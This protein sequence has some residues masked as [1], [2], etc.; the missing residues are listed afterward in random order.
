M[1]LEEPVMLSDH[2]F[3][4]V[5]EDLQSQD[6]SLRVATLKG[7]QRHPSE[8]ARVLS[9]LEVMLDDFTPCVVMLPHH[10]GELRWLAAY[11]LAAERAAMDINDPVTLKDVLKPL[12]I[13]EL[14]T[15]Q[16]KFSLS[17]QKGIEG[18]LE[19]VQILREKKQLPFYDLKLLPSDIGNKRI[20]S[21]NI[22]VEGAKKS[23]PLTGAALAKKVEELEKLS[24]EEKAIACGYYTVTKDGNKHVN[25]INFFSAIIK[26]KYIQSEMGGHEETHY[27]KK[28]SKKRKVKM[29]NIY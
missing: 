10:F 18:M 9:Y 22:Q 28:K 6:L 21:E 3:D 14:I 26:N 4:E 23:K 25:M 16:E 1:G 12:N 20:Q 15:I 11:A 19:V 29:Q 7:I 13:E 8:D 27:S 24:E 2:E 5:L 17:N